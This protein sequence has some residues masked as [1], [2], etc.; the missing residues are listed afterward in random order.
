MEEQFILNRL[1]E[2]AIDTYTMVVVL[3]RASQAIESKSPSAAHEALMAKVWCNE[4]SFEV[5]I[6]NILNS[7]TEICFG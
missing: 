1:A 5:V 2:A 3:S 6:C 4:V 7:F